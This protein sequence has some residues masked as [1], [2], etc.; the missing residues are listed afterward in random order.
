M[1][2]TVTRFMVEVTL[3]GDPNSPDGATVRIGVD[4]FAPLA[5]MM[6]ATEHMMTM[7]AA[8]SHT[9]FERSLELLCEGARK[10]NILKFGGNPKQ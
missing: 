7:F 9:S 1:K 6:A 10:N 2:T 4:G 5:A 8:S 3:K